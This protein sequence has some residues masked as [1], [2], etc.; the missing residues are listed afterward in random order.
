MDFGKI[1]RGNLD[2]LI[3]NKLGKASDKVIQKPAFGVDTGIVKTNKNQSLIV[4]SDPASFI[5]A[6][7]I[8]ESAWLTVILSA[9][10]IATS[11]CLPEYAQFVLNLSHNITAKELTEY[12]AYIHQFCADIGIAITGGHT[13]FDD[14]GSSTL[15]GGVTMFSLADQD[16]VKSASF[17]QPDQALILTKS[18]ALSSSAILAKSFPTHTKKHMG[19]EAYQRLANSFYQ[20]SILPEV[21]ALKKH[22]EILQEISAMHDVTEGGCLGAVYELCKASNLGVHIDAEKIIIGKDQEKICALFGINPLRSTGAGS[23]LM[24][25]SKNATSAIL[26]IMENNNIAAAL[27]G[28]TQLQKNGKNIVDKTEEKELTYWEKDPYWD[29]FFKA[30]EQKLT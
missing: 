11:G 10:D 1:D 7:G 4:A 8:K 9:N 17:A 20:T 3:Q 13:G 2:N 25:C 22:P 28:Q 19:K 26:E 30:V 18:A 14:I 16:K 15:A 21:K 23:L 5:P 12:W 6:L 24:A 29:A 27:I